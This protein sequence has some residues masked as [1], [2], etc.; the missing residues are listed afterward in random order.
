[1][2]RQPRLRQLFALRFDVECPRF[3]GHRVH[4]TGG[5]PVSILLQLWFY[6]IH[7]MTSTRRDV[8]AQHLERKLG[9]TYKTIWR[10]FNLIRNQLMAGV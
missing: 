8:S 6:A 10:M 2:P 9:V 1:M 4:E 7:L 3:C 5:G